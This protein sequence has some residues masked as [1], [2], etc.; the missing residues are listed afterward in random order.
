MPDPTSRVPVAEFDSR[1]I[2]RPDRSLLTYYMLCAAMSG[3]AFPLVALPLYFKYQTLRFRFDADGVS[4]SYGILFR[5]ETYLTYR[6]IQD[7]HVTRNIIQRWMG[8]ATVA[9]QTASG[10]SGA[11]MSLEGV[12]DYD[13]LRDFLYQQMRGAKGIDE[14]VAARSE[15]MPPPAADEALGLLREIRD[16]LAAVAARA[17]P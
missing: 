4:M 15:A 7:I 2:T 16:A 1:T 14:P 5:R 13:A 3:P 6:R 12:L 10:T 11:E 9:V 17:K 8:L